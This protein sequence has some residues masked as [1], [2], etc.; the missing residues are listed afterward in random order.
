MGHEGATAPAFEREDSELEDAAQQAGLADIEIPRRGT[1]AYQRLLQAAENY[2]S[3]VKRLEKPSYVPPSSDSENYFFKP[4]PITNSSDSERRKY[5]EELCMMLF[6]KRR[7]ELPL[8]T[9]AKISDFAA[10]VTGHDEYVGC[11]EK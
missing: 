4:K 7:N 11:F 1:A 10:H 6:G 9:L 2:I 8:A 5:H 3:E